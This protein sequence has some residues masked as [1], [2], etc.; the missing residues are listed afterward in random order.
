MPDI[1]G[2]TGSPARPRRARSLRWL[3]VVTAAALVVVVA[4]TDSHTGT[5]GVFKVVVCDAWSVTLRD[6]TVLTPPPEAIQ[7]EVQVPGGFGPCWDLPARVT[8]ED[9]R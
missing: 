9:L 6:G 8:M 7:G 3:I 1:D 2:A 4:I 5:F